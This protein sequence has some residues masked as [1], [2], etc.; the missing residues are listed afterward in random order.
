MLCNTAVFAGESETWTGLY[1]AG[2][3]ALDQQRLDQAEELFRKARGLA[4]KTS[5]TNSPEYEK[6][7]LRLAAALNLRAKVNEAQTLYLQVLNSLSKKYGAKSAQLAPILLDLGSIQEAAGDHTSAISY[8][9]RALQINE[10]NYGPYSPAVA[11]SLQNIGRANYKLGNKQEART[12]LKKSI[13][14]LSL[15]PDLQASQQMQGLMKDYGD[16]LKGDDNSNSELLNDF[17]K[18]MLPTKKDAQP[19][20]IQPAASSLPKDDIRAATTNAGNESAWQQQSRIQFNDTMKAEA[21]YDPQVLGR[22]FN[23]PTADTTL[24]PAYKVLNDSIF[25]QSHYEKGED[26]YKRQ[27]AADVDA[28]GAEHPSVANDMV[29]LARLY[30]SQQKYSAAEP[31]LQRAQTIYEKVY[32]K[33]NI[34]TLNTRVALASAYFHLGNVDK[35]AEIYRSALNNGQSSLSPNSME[36]AKILNELGYLYFHQ[37]KLQEARTFYEWALASTEGAVGQQSPLLAACLRD[38]AQVLRSLGETSQAGDA[39]AK[40]SKILANAH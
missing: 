27:I 13:S 6:C 37:G 30:L 39:E 8:Y 16:L 18:D 29:G 31:L 1:Q 28:L 23:R 5:G 9:K 25:N 24:D 10:E 17:Q 21:N 34:L 40:A 2:Q 3:A 22:S 19:A 32:G 36:T 14:I 12:H 20:S 26:Y 35:A 4:Q 11:N 33:D 7:T 38:Y 15:D